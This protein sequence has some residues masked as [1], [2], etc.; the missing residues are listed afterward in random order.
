MI[1]AGLHDVA[2]A[3][4]RCAVGL[5]HTNQAR[6][7]HDAISALSLY[8]ISYGTFPYMNIVLTKPSDV[9]TW[10]SLS[11]WSQHHGL[12]GVRQGPG[13]RAW[14]CIRVDMGCS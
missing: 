12:H 8:Y 14:Q 5:C 4:R 13:T 11:Q 6:A 2:A 1:G 9:W 7:T 10:R 3:D